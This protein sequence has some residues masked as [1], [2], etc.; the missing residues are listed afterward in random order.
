MQQP[1]P[2]AAVV[3]GLG[4]TVPSRVVTN[5]M[6]AA[7][8]DTSDEWIRRRTG[9]RQRHVVEP[10]GATSD[11]AVDAGALAIKSAA[12]NGVEGADMVVLATTT[13]DHRC[14]ATAPEVATRLGLR[15]VAAFDVAAVCSGFVYGLA[16]GAGA[17]AAGHV[18]RVLVIG[19]EAFTTIINPEDRTTAA[20][21]GDGAGAIVLRAGAADEPGALLGFDLGSDGSNAQL[22]IVPAGGSRQRSDP[23]PPE[24]GSEYFTMQGAAVFRNAVVRMTE[25]A[26]IVLGQTGWVIDEVDWF[27]GHQANIRILTAVADELGLPHSRAVI[28]V[29]RVGNTSAASIPLALADAAADG[30]L[31]A[32]HRVLLTAFGG[33]L[34]WGSATLRWPDLHIT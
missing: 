29:D 15:G 2:R 23:N 31:Q 10:G 5:D 33:G 7:R 30:R 27:V 20:I 14:P 34:T 32:G 6:L 13:P 24:P 28:N 16:V 26:R 21:F 22:I 17:I 19:A 12:H 3:A 4:A 8:L 1:S 11:L 18:E 9:I 25:S